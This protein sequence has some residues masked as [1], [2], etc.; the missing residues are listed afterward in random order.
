MF[1]RQWQSYMLVKWWEGLHV[2]VYVPCKCVCMMRT[3]CM[4]VGREAVGWFYI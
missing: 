4:H 1:A 3:V 2:C